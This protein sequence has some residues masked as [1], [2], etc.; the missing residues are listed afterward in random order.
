MTARTPYVLRVEA[1]E[2]L[3]LVIAGFGEWRVA[4]HT[5]DGL[6]IVG[7]MVGDGTLWQFN[8]FEAN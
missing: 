6:R 1:I 5:R 4:L 2:Q 8:T 3:R 7:R